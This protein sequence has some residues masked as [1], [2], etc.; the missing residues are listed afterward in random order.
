MP[1][2]H[3]FL[4]LLSRQ[5]AQV[6]RC[7]NMAQSLVCFDLSRLK[8]N[9]QPLCSPEDCLTPTSAVRCFVATTTHIKRL[10]IT[11]RKY[12][13]HYQHSENSPRGNRELQKFLWETQITNS[14]PI[15]LTKELS[16]SLSS[17]PGM[18]AVPF[19]ETAHIT[20]FSHHFFSHE[21]NTAT[22][23]SQSQRLV[24]P[25][26]HPWSLA[27][28]ARPGLWMLTDLCWEVRLFDTTQ[29]FCTFFMQKPA[30]SSLDD[31]RLPS[32]LQPPAPCLNLAFHLSL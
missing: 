12:N 17:G 13:V 15:S 2:P 14:L 28:I 16:L 7:Q 31:C 24:V 21:T 11:T 6:C 10:K 26:S 27:H 32:T 30:T 5:P 19:L 3:H 9:T 25:P 20:T 4:G 29:M 18:S 1:R 8:F 22:N 23:L